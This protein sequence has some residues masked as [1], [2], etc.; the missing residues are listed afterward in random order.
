M[1]KMQLWSVYLPSIIICIRNKKRKVEYEH[2]LS[3]FLSTMK[4][5]KMYYEHSYSIANFLSS[6]ENK[7]WMFMLHFPF[8]HFEC[9]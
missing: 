9:K 7:K 4:T 2:P 6:M 5:E 1:N 8:F 3:I